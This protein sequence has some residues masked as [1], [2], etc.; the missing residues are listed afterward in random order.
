MVAELGDFRIWLTILA[1]QPGKGAY[2]MLIEFARAGSF[3][4]TDSA[5]NLY[6][7]VITRECI[8]GAISEIAPQQFLRTHDGKAVSR[9]S[10]GRY[11][12]VETGMLLSSNDPCCP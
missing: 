8:S 1:F 11:K 7:V 6:E 2:A 10:K 12:V 3:I 4:A 5:L 9:R